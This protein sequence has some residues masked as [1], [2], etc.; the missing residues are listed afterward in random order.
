MKA[1]MANNADLQDR[2]SDAQPDLGANRHPPKRAGRIMIN[3]DAPLQMRQRC[4]GWRPDSCRVW[5]RAR[6]GMTVAGSIIVR[7]DFRCR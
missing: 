4:I 3:P 5:P 7:S 6:P 2:D 1:A